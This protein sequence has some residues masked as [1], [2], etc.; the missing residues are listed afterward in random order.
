MA[1]SQKSQGKEKLS[2]KEKLE[3]KKDGQKFQEQLKTV[4][5]DNN[6]V[7]ICVVQPVNDLLVYR[8]CCRRWA[9][10]SS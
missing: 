6:L 3:L 8:L 10:F 4:I 2:R 7:E 1:R 9:L 5:F